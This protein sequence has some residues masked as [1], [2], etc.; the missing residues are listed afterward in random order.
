[1]RSRRRFWH[2]GVLLLVAAVGVHVLYGLLG[3]G[4]LVG[5]AAGY[6]YAGV[7]VVW[8]EKTKVREGESRSW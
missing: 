4:A 3:V 1:M 8:A 6:V 2:A 7:V 5:A